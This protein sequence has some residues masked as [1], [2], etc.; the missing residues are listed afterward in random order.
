MKAVGLR[1]GIVLVG[2]LALVACGES[3]GG[4]DD[5]DDDSGGSSA[6]G[7]AGRGGASG[8][9]GGG[10]RAGSSGA[11][12]AGG[13]SAGASGA[14]S[15]GAGSGAGRAGAAGAGASAGASGGEAG[16]GA[17]GG[18][19]GGG[20]SGAGAVGGAIEALRETLNAFCE[21]AA[22]CCAENG[23]PAMLEDCASGEPAHE[24]ALTGI[25]SG[26]VTVDMTALGRCRDAYASADACNYNV[27]IA[28]CEGVFVGHRQVGEPCG[29]GYDCDRA[30]A[31]MSCMFASSSD[32][33]GVCKEIVRA[34]LDEPCDFFCRA[35][36]DCSGSTLGTT[37]PVAFCYE[38]DGLFC[39]WL[40]TGS[41]CR[42]IAAVGDPCDDF[43]SFDACGS[44]AR[45]NGTCV[46]LGD[47]GDPCGDG[48]LSRFTCEDDV[49]TDP[50]W[51]REH[52][53]SGE[54]FVP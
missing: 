6:A 54:R 49:C 42:P 14:L 19:A 44:V 53:C 17:S 5:D 15:G 34:G 16:G 39:E 28:A 50:T 36:E 9:K 1:N 11:S 47:Y 3:T 13:V 52:T 31:Q 8:G 46:A 4:A 2:W 45:C 26:A 43:E 29:G 18:G 37:E 24:E 25:E 30:N 41:V 40:E 10:G 35:G 22:T 7:A 48:C 21:A 33:P 38:D 12:G 20:A 51:A 32:E 23:V 27:L